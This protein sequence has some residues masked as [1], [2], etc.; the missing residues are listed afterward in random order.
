MDRHRPIRQPLKDGHTSP[1]SQR[2]QS[3]L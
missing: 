3:R 1:I 2:I